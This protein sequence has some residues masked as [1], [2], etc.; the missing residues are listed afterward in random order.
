MK[1]TLT[2]AITIVML[3]ACF[4]AVSA[5]DLITNGGFESPVNTQSWQVYPDGYAGLSWTVE[6]GIG[7]LPANPPGVPTLEIETLS[8]L[9][10]TPDEGNQYAELD[11]YANANI[12]QMVS[13]TKGV[14]YHI[15]YAQTCRP[16]ESGATSIL[17]VYLD[18]ELLQ[19]T[20]CDQ[21]LTWKTNT[22]DVTP[23]ADGTAKLMFADEGLTVQSYG[24]LLDDVRME[25]EENHEVP[26]PEFP[27]VALPAAMVVGL[28]GAVLLIQKSKED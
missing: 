21:T 11:S 12:S 5:A 2:L 22:V 16:Q 8:T 7:P 6:Q 25:Y 24:V 10:L 14:T 23:S 28:I 26:V 13:L 20:P 15:S 1:K 27:T 17:G 4:G 9:G 3:L 18:G 19:S